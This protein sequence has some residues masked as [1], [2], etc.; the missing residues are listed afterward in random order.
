MSTS[1]VK[2]FLDCADRATDAFSFPQEQKDILKNYFAVLKTQSET[3]NRAELYYSQIFDGTSTEIP[4]QICT[5]ND[6]ESGML[7]A[8]IYLA[9]LWALDTIML[10][11]GI[12]K[13]YI[14][15]AEWHY[16][17]LF[18]RNRKRYGSYGFCGMY[19]DGMVQYI[20]P[21]SYTLGRLTFE[22]GTF[23]QNRT[24]YCVYQNTENGKTLPIASE[25]FFY[26]ANGRRVP[27]GD[28]VPNVFQPTCS[29]QNGELRGYTFDENG[30][31][32]K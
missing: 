31:L 2:I 15:K 23:A 26:L 8:A 11:R 17:N 14:Q 19:R 9:R 30:Y 28:D 24:P 6:R 21:R 32:V 25:G 20:L 4:T 5:Q 29:I 16:Q 1:T 7:F 12:P 3:I 10:E 27:N 13:K 22:M 18:E